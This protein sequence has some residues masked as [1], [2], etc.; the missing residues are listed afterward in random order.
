[1][2]NIIFFLKPTKGKIFSSILVGVIVCYVIPFVLSIYDVFFVGHIDG[3]GGLPCKGGGEVGFP[4]KFYESEEVCTLD[5]FPPLKYAINYYYFLLD[6]FVWYII[7]I[8]FILF[9]NQ[10]DNVKYK[11]K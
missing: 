9:K 6:L 8:S 11:I 4:L 5:V 2:K 3:A 7:A 1:M 10:N